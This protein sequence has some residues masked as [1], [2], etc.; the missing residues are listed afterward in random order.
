MYNSFFNKSMNKV[1]KNKI[2]NINIR[3]KGS[4]ENQIGKFNIHK[5]ILTID[6]LS[7]SIYTYIIPE[8]SREGLNCSIDMRVS[9]KG[10]ITFKI[11]EHRDAN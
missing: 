10:V 7:E 9:F 2:H 8:T 3:K 4:T 5:Y 6:F 1:Q 11:K